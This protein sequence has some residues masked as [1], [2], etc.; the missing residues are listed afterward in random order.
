MCWLFAEIE[1]AKNILKIAEAGRNII[2]S[3]VMVPSFVFCVFILQSISSYFHANV[4]EFVHKH[5]NFLFKPSFIFMG[6]NVDISFS[7][8]TL[9]TIL[10]MNLSLIA[11]A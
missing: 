7:G 4:I 5:K 8:S 10:I 3:Q 1:F 11:E 6:R 2:F 9:I